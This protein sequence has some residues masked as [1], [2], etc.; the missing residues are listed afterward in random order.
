MN[1]LHI[2]FGLCLISS[3]V[4]GIVSNWWAVADFVGVVVPLLLIVFGVVSVLAGVTLITTKKEYV[5]K[6]S[7][8]PLSHP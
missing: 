6:N 8:E 2:L 5:H 3:G 4:Y 1:L 7:G